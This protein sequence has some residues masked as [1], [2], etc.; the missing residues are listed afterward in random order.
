MSKELAQTVGG[1][2]IAALFAI[3]AALAVFATVAG[4]WREASA[5]DVTNWTGAAVESAGNPVLGDTV[6]WTVTV[7]P[8]T[9]APSSG[10]TSGNTHIVVKLNLDSGV[11]LDDIA[12]DNAIDCTVDETPSGNAN[13][14]V[15]NSANGPLSGDTGE[16]QCTF[17][18]AAPGNPFIFEISAR[19]VAADDQDTADLIVYWEDLGETALTGGADSVTDGEI[20]IDAPELTVTKTDDCSSVEAGDACSFTIVV[21]NPGSVDLTGVNI[22]DTIP[23]GLDAGAINS[24]ADAGSSVDCSASSGNNVSCTAAIDQGDS[25]TVIV[26]VEVDDTVACG[27][28]DIVNTAVA[29]VTFDGDLVISDSDSTT[30]EVD[31]CAVDVNDVDDGLYHL[32]PWGDWVEGR[33]DPNNLI[34]YVHM[35]CLDDDNGTA[36]SGP[37]NTTASVDI[38]GI[39]GNVLTSTGI[40]WRIQTISGSADLNGQQLVLK[41]FDGDSL[42]EECVQWYSNH[43]GEQNVTIIDSQGEVIADWADGGTA[44]VTASCG[45]GNAAGDCAPI[46]SYTP[47]V[48]E[49]NVLEPTDI[50]TDGGKSPDNSVEGTIITKSVLFDPSDSMYKYIGAGGAQQYVKL[51]EHVFGSHNGWSG[52]VDG[53][54]VTFEISGTCGYAVIDP[55]TASDYKTT[56]EGDS[57]IYALGSPTATTRTSGGVPINFWVSTYD[58]D[59]L[60]NAYTTITIS[61]DY[62]TTIGSFPPDPVEETVTIKWVSTV[63]S[64][65]VFLAWAGQRIILEHDWRLPEGDVDGDAGDPDPDPLGVCAF[66]YGRTGSNGTFQVDYIKGQGPGNFLKGLGAVL[67][68]SDQA[69]VE[70]E[71]DDSD[72]TDGSDIIME[73]QGSCISRVLYESEDQGQVDIEAFVNDEDLSEGEYLNQTK[74]A[75]VIYYMKLESVSVSLVDDVA[76]PYHN[77]SGTDWSPGNPWDA[78]KD[79]DT[80]DWNV[81]KDLLVRARVKGWFTASNATGRAAGTDTN[82]GVLPAG[83]W[84]MPDDWPLLAGGPADPADGS[85]AKG[86]AEAYRPEFDIM[87][88]PNNSSGYALDIPEG[89]VSSTGASYIPV[90]ALA[91]AMDQVTTTIVVPY[92]YPLSACPTGVIRIDSE[93]MYV[94]GLTGT[95]NATFTTW[96]YKGV[97]RTQATG[98]PAANHDAGA[99]ITCRIPTSMPFEGPYSLLDSRSLT[100]PSAALSNWDSNNVRKTMW[101]D[102]DVDMWDAPM[103]PSMLTVSI[104]GAGFIKQVLKQDVYFKGTA[105]STSGQVYP[106]PYYIVNIP[107]S[108]F[109][110]ANV[111]GGGYYWNS[112]GND[113]PGCAKTAAAPDCNDA[114]GLGQGVYRF[115]RPAI[116]GSNP[117]GVKDS[118]VTTTQAAELAAIRTAYGDPTI[119]RD[120]VVYTDNHGEAMVAANGDFK[121]DYSGC[122]T[123]ALGGGKHCAPGDKVGASTLTAVADYPDF[124]GKHYPLLSN[125]ATVNWTWGGYKDVTIEDGETEQYKYVVFHAVDRDGFCSQYVYE[126]DLGY[127]VPELLHPV[128]TSATNDEF[129]GNPSET[130]DFMIDSGEGIILTTS[131]GASSSSTYTKQF[132]EGITTFSTAE[133]EPAVSGLKEFPLSSLAA[134][135]AT[136]E[137]QAWIKVSNSLLGILDILVIAHDDEGDVGFDKIIDLQSTM[138]YSLSF[139][140]TLITWAGQDGIATADALKGS[141]GATNDITSSVTAVY[142]WDAAAQAWLGYFPSA[143]PVPGANDLTKLNEGDAYWIAITGPGSVTWT[144]ATNVD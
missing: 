6:T 47:L 34:G 130:V 97:A 48:K 43:T 1:K 142:G 60:M 82:G 59:S 90:S 32:D 24:S 71:A 127:D 9:S 68:G 115:W 118:S 16:V 135:G 81:S 50:T 38:D 2:K 124:R 36:Y 11:V 74:I 86:I 7:T 98:G 83:R 70:V 33:D 110:P 144:I 57:S 77:V 42:V 139:R 14:T 131:D 64:K 12:V 66:D 18:V 103:P 23:S 13:H 19:I 53:A 92:A 78:S 123:N 49:W 20:T 39:E 54:T 15:Q 76:K 141:G 137:C 17:P 3:L 45:T 72:Q 105:N 65:Q 99:S 10:Q 114:S 120:L 107:D 35:V 117:L 109:I 143:V 52:L 96:T 129:N 94:G 87:I 29:E 40:R 31:E 21:S 91:A 88:A 75:F 44:D 56:V 30:V 122:A 4:T 138:S 100:G 136:D 62:P 102:S 41:D 37:I 95:A 140:W 51:D 108:P 112:W 26:A 28:D 69:T 106:N 128:L 63:P 93:D 84:V 27:D 73:P 67:N 116:I 126:E 58:C 121:L 46:G 80:V 5:E 133:N 104:R 113:G 25:V 119:A 132:A 111:E 134:T 125:V 55:N 61:V 85:D 8:T 79:V 89:F 22:S 101:P